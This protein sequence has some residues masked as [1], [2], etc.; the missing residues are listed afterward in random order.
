MIY[1]VHIIGNS[2]VT[3]V[4]H[5][6]NFDEAAAESKRI[7]KEDNREM[8]LPFDDPYVIAGQATIGMEILQQT[9]G[10]PLDAVFLPCG[11]GGMLAGVALWV[12]IYHCISSCSLYR[13]WHSTGNIRRVYLHDIIAQLYGII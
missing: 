12:N 10:R 13:S 1:L 4:L 9:T 11:G 5:G 7:E 8:I 6:N 3:I 2:N